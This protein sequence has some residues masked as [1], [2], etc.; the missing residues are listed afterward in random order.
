MFKAQP[1][2]GKLRCLQ[3][4]E[5]AEHHTA[6]IFNVS[7]AVDVGLPE[8]KRVV[9][10]KCCLDWGHLSGRIHR[11]DAYT[12]RDTVRADHVVL[13]REVARLYAILRDR[14]QSDLIDKVPAPFA[15]ARLRGSLC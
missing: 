6:P 4:G 9:G 12:R 11:Q 7:C 8:P 14:E 5:L 3:V 1:S 15:L 13:R 2:T 10:G